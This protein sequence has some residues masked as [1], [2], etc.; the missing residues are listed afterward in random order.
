[1]TLTLLVD[2][3]VRSLQVG[4]MY[5]LMAIGLTLTLAVIKLPNFAHAE[6]ITTGAYVAL[7][8]SLSVSS[9]PLLVLGMA[10]LV[11]AIV[12][13][14]SHR[15]VYRPLSKHN[16]SMY[17]LILSSFAVGLILRYIIFLLVDRTDLFDKRIQV[18]QKILVQNDWLTLTNIF[19]WVVPTSIGL[20]IALSLV[21]HYTE[22][23]REMRA[24]ADNL[25][26]AKV[27]GIPVERVIDLTWLVVGALTGVGGA[28]WGLY[29]FV[30]PMV[31]WL[32]ILSVFAAS[33]LG[34]MTSFV[35]TIL[36]AYL[37]AFCENTLMLALN[38]W[39][40]ISFSFKPA[41]PFIIII[42]V[43][44]IRPQGFS[45]LSIHRGRQLSSASSSQVREA[46]TSQ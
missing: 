38:S 25:T 45:G 4:S 46:P 16:P 35:G 6:L 42:M 28:L 22:L 37:V 23:G 30:N 13:L 8:V 21:L 1:M 41:I 18:Q 5:A 7:V 36:G 33:I 27:L 3:L 26:L 15:A 40:G 20:V 34:G 24:L 12:A 29:T 31:G 2:S 9:N 39:F 11:T 44:L 32:G 10:A 19:I 17:T 43:L 14:G